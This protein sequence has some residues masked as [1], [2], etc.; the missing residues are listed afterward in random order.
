[1]RS[2]RLSVRA[3]RPRP[4]AS[5]PGRETGIGWRRNPDLA[6]PAG[7]PRDAH[8]PARPPPIRTVLVPVDGSAASEHALPLATSI[9]RRAGA[10]VVLAHVYSPLHAPRDPKQFRFSEPLLPLG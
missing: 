4:W 3:D 6:A 7:V 1:M 10:Q 9:A 5:L 2:N 8:S